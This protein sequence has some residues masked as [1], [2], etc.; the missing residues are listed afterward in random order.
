M[1]DI[2][3]DSHRKVIFPTKYHGDVSL[4]EKKWSIIC[5]QPE[6]RY[7]KYN[8]DKIPTTLINPDYVR[9]HKSNPNQFLYYKAFDCYKITETAEIPLKSGFCCVIIDMS[10]AR[11]CT[12]MPTRKIK[13]G[14][15]FKLPRT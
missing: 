1:A 5:L 14:V 6:R 4:S 8:G 3:F 9:H 11:V 7:Y 2:I 15:E 13:K 10:T 12:V